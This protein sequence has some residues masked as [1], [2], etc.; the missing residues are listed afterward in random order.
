MSNSTLLTGWEVVRFNAIDQ[1]VSANQVG[2]YIYLTERM[3]AREY[4][5]NDLYTA[6]LADAQDF[7]DLEEYRS[8][9]T[10]LVDHLVIYRGLVFK[11]LQNA[12]S[13]HLPSDPS[14]W[15]LEDKFTED[16][17]NDFWI[18]HLR[19]F[20]ATS[21]WDRASRFLY[22]QVKAKGIV[23]QADPQTGANPISKEEYAQ[24]RRDVRLL[25][26]HM[27]SNMEEWVTDNIEN[28]EYIA[29]GIYLLNDFLQFS[30]GKN[31]FKPTARRF[32]F[33]DEYNRDPYPV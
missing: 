11:S 19:E 21:T 12:N 2:R 20:L 30:C 3:L 25:Q 7:S 24:Y 27:S 4:I 16:A 15:V 8:T 6:M 32:Y 31:K 13:G 23:N 9:T 1:N 18:K 29:D 17:Y 22:T 10:Y 33:R 26:V 28:P 14:W 5:G